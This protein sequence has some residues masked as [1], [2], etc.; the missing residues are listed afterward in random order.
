[1]KLNS[2][3][4]LIDE[5]TAYLMWT[6]D[7]TIRNAKKNTENSV[8][9]LCRT[10][11]HLLIFSDK[12]C[13]LLIFNLF[14]AMARPI[15]QIII[16]VIC[17]VCM[18]CALRCVVHLLCIFPLNRISLSSLFF[19]RCKRARTQLRQQAKWKSNSFHLRPSLSCRV[20]G[21]VIRICSRNNGPLC[22]ARPIDHQCKC[23]RANFPLS[24]FL[25]F[26]FLAR[27]PLCFLVVFF[28]PLF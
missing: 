28:V 19:G 25:S 4:V 8:L 14:I 17:T 22:A 13:F 18:H 3:R 21:V 1:M 26:R 12:E 23:A 5:T 7:Y 2:F 16:F 27:N 9:A 24:F 6:K 20:S 11:L 15:I 10:N